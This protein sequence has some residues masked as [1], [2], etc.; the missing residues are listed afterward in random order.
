VLSYFCARRAIIAA[1]PCENGAARLVAREHAGL[2]IPPTGD[3]LVDAARVL[4][5]DEQCRERAAA[6]A[7]AYAEAAFDV[8]DK[9]ARFDAVLG[10]DAR[11]VPVASGGEDR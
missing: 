10:E 9:A 11:A 3:A 6:S 2:A 7:R 8:D 5:A 4:V 1:M